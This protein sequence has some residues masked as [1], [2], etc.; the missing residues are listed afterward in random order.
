M[1]SGPRPLEPTTVSD[2]PHR[3]VFGRS[4]ATMLL[5]KKIPSRQHRS[6]AEEVLPVIG[7]RKQCHPRDRGRCGPMR[8]LGKVKIC[9]AKFERPGARA[10]EVALTTGKDGIVTLD[11]NFIHI[12]LYGYA[13]GTG[14][15]RLRRDSYLSERAAASVDILRLGP[16]GKAWPPIGLRRR[17][18]KRAWLQRSGVAGGCG[19]SFPTQEMRRFY[20]YAATAFR[21]N[22]LTLRARRSRQADSSGIHPGLAAAWSS[23]GAE[24]RILRRIV[25][26]MKQVTW[27]M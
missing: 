7:M 12:G 9:M 2:A 17:I 19:S 14:K 8:L 1:R 15:S 11:S 27:K 5:D 4:I 20:G 18:R 24:G 13:C 22:S 3:T 23:L 25:E 16:Q 26:A 6:D 10:S 21:R